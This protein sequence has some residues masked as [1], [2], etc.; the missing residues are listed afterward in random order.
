VIGLAAGQLANIRHNRDRLL[1]IVPRIV[2]VLCTTHRQ[3]GLPTIV[4]LSVKTVELGTVSSG[5][6]A[7]DHLFLPASRPSWSPCLIRARCR[8]HTAL[9]GSL[10]G[11]DRE[12]FK[13]EN[14]HAVFLQID[15]LLSMQ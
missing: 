4:P 7:G 13:V 10:L 6:N 14:R 5:N 2:K 11:E 9:L 8:S 12:P 3:S 1:R 15:D